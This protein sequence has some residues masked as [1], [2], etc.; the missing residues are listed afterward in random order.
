MQVWDLISAHRHLVAYLE[1]SGVDAPRTAADVL[2]SHALGIR[3]IDIYAHFDRPVTREQL[4]SVN[5][6]AVQLKRGVPLQHVVGSA[7]FL[8]Y[9]FAV[10]PGVLIPR[11]ET[12]GLVDHAVALLKEQ[13]FANPRIADIGCG[14]GV[15]AVSMLKLMPCAA[16]VAV[17]INPAAL[18]LTEQN[19]ETLGVAERLTIY[20][21]DLFQPLRERREPPFDCIISNPPYVRTGDI[22]KLDPIVRDHDPRAALD[23]GADG[24]DVIRKLID[25]SREFLNKNGILAMEFGMGQESAVA[26]LAQNAGYGGIRIEKD[27]AGMPRCLLA[28]NDS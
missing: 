2:L 19:A 11:P 13:E 15:I 17:D 20:K 7:Q 25:E 28:I 22:E 3:R 16:A 21:G 18:K 12:E 26:E 6:L 4:D 9:T 1:K 27:L 24:L 10:A 8:S 23:G 5:A 14:A